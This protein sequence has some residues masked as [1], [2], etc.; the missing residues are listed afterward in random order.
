MVG[1]FDDGSRI[2]AD[3]EFRPAGGLVLAYTD[4]EGTAFAGADNLV[5]MALLENG[6]GIGTHD[7]L[8][9]EL[10]GIVE[11]AFV[12]DHHEFD[13]LDE[14]FGVG[15]AAEGHAVFL[16]FGAEGFVVLDDAV[17]Y[18]R[19]VFGLGDMRVSVGG[20][21]FAMSGPAGV[22]DADGAADVLVLD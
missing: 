6:N 8:E 1:V 21:G 10:D 2:G 15:L 22:G 20:V 16:Q 4:D 9:R 11:V 5:G 13:Q 12:G 19:E 17:V 14:H 3:V 7:V 18:Q